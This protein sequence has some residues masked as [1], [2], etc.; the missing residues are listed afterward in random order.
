LNV[1][2]DPVD[3]VPKSLPP[4][5]VCLVHHIELSEAGWWDQ[6]VQRF[7]IAAV[8]STGAIHPLELPD[9][10]RRD[11]AIE[12]STEVVSEHVVALIRD[13]DFIE[14]PTSGSS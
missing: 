11:Y 14:L 12:I 10:I 7:L 8:A 13:G 5:L 2:Y 9:V 1:A 4:E 3:P 6:A